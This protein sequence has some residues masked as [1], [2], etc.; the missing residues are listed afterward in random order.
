M[1]KHA[2]RGSLISSKA[3]ER[4][5]PER[6]RPRRHTRATAIYMADDKSKKQATLRTWHERTR[7]MRQGENRWKGVGN[8]AIPKFGGTEIR[9][10]H[11]GYLG[12]C[13][14]RN[15]TA[16]KRAG[17][18]RCVTESC[19]WNSVGFSRTQSERIMERSVASLILLGW[20]SN[21]FLFLLHSLWKDH[22]SM[23]LHG[24][25]HLL[26]EK[27]SHP[28]WGIYIYVLRVAYDR[29]SIVTSERR[30]FSSFLRN[31]RNIQLHYIKQIL[32]IHSYSVLNCQCKYYI[33]SQ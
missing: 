11:R 33:I 4:S 28:L 21:V 13:N 7:R 20:L 23:N 32:F 24:G 26:C 10:I 22:L 27:F 17:I 14:S 29:N 8:G 1:K 31:N 9:I 3:K 12:L 16:A 30:N 25:N 2:G 19:L 15:W 6:V 18:S 5:G